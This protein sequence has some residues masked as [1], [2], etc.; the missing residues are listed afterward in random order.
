MGLVKQVRLGQS[1]L[2]I[3][4]IVVGCMSYGS[5]NWM[6]WVLDDKEKIFKILKHC[7]DNGL[8]TF[9]TADVYS[10]GFSERLLGEFLKKYNIRRETVVI[11]TKVNF[12]V[13]ETLDIA[14][15]K[16]PSESE[17]LDLANQG[18]LSRKH[19]LEGVKNSVER[20]GTYIDVLQIHRFDHEVPM[21]ETMRALNDVVVQG[22]TRYIGA[23]L[24]LATEFAELQFIAEKNGWFKF[25]SSQSYYNLLNREDERELIPFAKRH[26]VGL[27]PY[28]PN[29]RG[30]LCRPVG[31]V[32][33]REVVDKALHPRLVQDLSDDQIEIITRVEELSKKKN[34][35]MATISMAWTLYKGVNP[36]VGLSSIERVDEAIRA[37]EVELTK[38]EVDYLEE[39]YQPKFPRTK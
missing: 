24:M 9:D 30:R 33:E 29:A 32:T 17:A 10:N 5:K 27:I 20:L 38:E 26:G 19:I 7:Y 34:V 28:T 15:G 1:G 35:S 12:P 18:G 8:R 37:T 16:P 23:S 22:L 14:V 11:L 31:T 2:K 39:P 4:A 21:E 13:D 36:I 6:E 3:S 25:I